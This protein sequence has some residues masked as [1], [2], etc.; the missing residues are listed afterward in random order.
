MHPIM[1]EITINGKKTLMEL[2]MGASV[3]IISMEEKLTESSLILTTY[4]DEQ[5]K[6]AGQML[7]S[8]KYG[9]QQHQLPVYVVNDNGPSLMGRN[10]LPKITL[11]WKSLNLA[12]VP[13]SQTTRSPRDNWKQKVEAMVDAHKNVFKEGLG[14]GS[15]TS[16]NLVCCSINQCKS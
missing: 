11:N 10:W 3:L 9:K 5:L 2:N 7:V 13:D 4:S 1:V 15:D 16:V 14:E 12:S 8:M 6:I